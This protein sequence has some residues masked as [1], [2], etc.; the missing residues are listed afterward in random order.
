MCMVP[1]EFKT[2]HTPRINDLPN[3]VLL[4]ILQE[5]SGPSK[6][7]L[8]HPVEFA[9]DTF[10]NRFTRS[11]KV[12]RRVCH[13]WKGL[14]DAPLTH[15]SRVTTAVLDINYFATDEPCQHRNAERFRNHLRLSKS[16]LIVRLV[17]YPASYTYLRMTEEERRSAVA[18][19][20]NEI[21]RLSSY[22]DRLK[23]IT[24]LIGI[25]ELLPP[26]TAVLRSLGCN[27]DL[28]EMSIERGPLLLNPNPRGSITELHDVCHALPSLRRLSLSPIKVVDLPS[29]SCL[30]SL[31]SI[32]TLWGSVA[33]CDWDP[34]LH[35]A[36]L[37][38]N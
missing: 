19:F 1:M 26:T 37:S 27:S 29:S 20:S 22:G 28:E 5:A 35:S 38:K 4:F 21:Y 34:S 9:C 12:I 7:E 2:D 3:E 25:A 8:Q 33:I 18:A 17:A 23:K 32:L 10:L 16:L 6:N 15:T 11:A 31:D 24:L 36:I 30:T 13:R 14:L